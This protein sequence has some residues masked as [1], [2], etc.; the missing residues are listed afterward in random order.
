MKKALIIGLIAIYLVSAP[1]LV[2]GVQAKTNNKTVTKPVVKK[3]APAKKPVKKPAKKKVLGITSYIFNP[4]TGIVSCDMP[5]GKTIKVPKKDCDAVK[6]FWG[7]VKHSNP[8]ATAQPSGGNSGGSSNNSNNNP[9]PVIPTPTITDVNVWPCTSPSCNFISVVEVVGTGFTINTRVELV[10]Q[11][12]GVLTGGNSS[13]QIITDFYNVPAGT[14][15]VRVYSLNGDT[16]EVII[17]AA[18]VIN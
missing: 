15:N 3:K 8:P 5:D 6:A 13:T 17:P 12:A 7:S 4:L 18:V 9:A 1:L 2:S 14:Y 10:G 16:Q 11:A